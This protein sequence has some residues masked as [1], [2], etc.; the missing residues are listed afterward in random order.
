[1]NPIWPASL[2]QDPLRQGYGEEFG[3]DQARSQNDAGPHKVRPLSSASPDR[4]QLPFDCT[5]AQVAT[6]KTFVK[7]T[8]AQGSLAFDFLDP[9]EQV[10]L[11]YRFLEKPRLGTLS[12]TTWP[13]TIVI[14]RL[15]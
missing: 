14:E 4:L 2:P 9:R 11:S 13:V 12:E 6:L 8:L 1:M 7:D 5:R 10:T 15:P 3:M